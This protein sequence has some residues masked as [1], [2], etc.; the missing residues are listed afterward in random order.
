MEI[1]YIINLI[2]LALNF[3]PMY[4]EPTEYSYLIEIDI[5]MTYIFVG[6]GM[7]KFMGFGV[8][9]FFS[10]VFNVSEIITNLIALVNFF[11]F[12]EFF[13]LIS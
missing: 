12:S 11:I 4:K 10:N 6:E 5:I 8:K 2:I 13:N 1:L 9:E 7:I 3:Y